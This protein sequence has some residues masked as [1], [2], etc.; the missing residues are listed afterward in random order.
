MEQ[1]LQGAW[2]EKR[3]REL[4]EGLLGVVQSTP[5]SSSL[6]TLENEHKSWRAKAFMFLD[7][8]LAY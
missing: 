8:V 3:G 6:V 4:R 7:G 2:E 5:A 1:V